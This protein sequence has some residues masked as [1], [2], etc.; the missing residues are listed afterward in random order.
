MNRAPDPVVIIGLAIIALML[1]LVFPAGV[2]L[3]RGLGDYYVEADALTGGA[4]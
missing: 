4:P 2:S 1:A 3:W